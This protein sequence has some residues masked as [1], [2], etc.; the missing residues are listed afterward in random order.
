MEFKYGDTIITLHEPTNRRRELSRQVS[1]KLADQNLSPSGRSE[2]SALVA[3]TKSVSNGWQP[4][5]PDAPKEELI[6]GLEYWLDHIQVD[7][8]DQWM[9]AIFARNPDPVTRPQPLGDAA[10]PNS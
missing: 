1:Q 5:T 8:T 7:L 4:P 9:D 3:Y 10:D 6:A 2:F